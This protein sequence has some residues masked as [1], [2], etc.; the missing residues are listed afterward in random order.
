M[1]DRIQQ[2]YPEL[3]NQS[4]AKLIPVA[5]KTQETFIIK[6]QLSYRQSVNNQPDILAK[7]ASTVATQKSDNGSNDE[8]EVDNILRQSGIKLAVKQKSTPQLII[9]TDEQKIDSI[10]LKS[11]VSVVAVSSTRIIRP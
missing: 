8:Q 6:K 10:L 1:Y 9:P 5:Q 11:G 3:L 7:N 4:Q 2:T